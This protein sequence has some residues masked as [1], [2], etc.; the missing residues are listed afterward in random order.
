VTFFWL[1]KGGKY[2]YFDE[3]RKFLEA[4]HKYRS[5]TKN[6][7]KGAVVHTPRPHLPTG[8]DTKAELEA[9]VLNTDGK[10]F[11][12]YGE[13]HQWTHIPCLWKLAYFEDLELPHN[14][15]VMHTEKNISEALWS[16]IMDTEKTKD[17]IKARI[18]QQELCDRPNLDPQP[19]DVKGP[20]WTKRK[21]LFCPSRTERREIFQWIID[22]LF[23]PD[24]YA[25]NWMRGANLETL[26]VHGLKSH[27]YHVW[28]EWIM[29]IM[30][31]GYVDEQT[32]LVLVE[33]SYFF[34]RLC[35]KELD[36]EV[37]KKL[38]KQ[39]PELLYVQARDA[40]SARV[41]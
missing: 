39:A 36:R 11:V 6:F 21:A 4:N 23:F 19:P 37:V 16:T 29:P 5:D 13:T 1:K 8:K 14:I 24:G 15:D 32:W 9:I 27:D 20:R 26:Q 7:K 33:L 12:G 34:C 25:A 17:N 10:Y 38:D 28:L 30:I 35:A 3:H 22:C 41:L 2:S 31:R 18:D 40:R